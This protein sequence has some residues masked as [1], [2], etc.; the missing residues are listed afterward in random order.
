M[1]SVGSKCVE[2]DHLLWEGFESVALPVKTEWYKELRVD[3]WTRGMNSQCKSL[4]ST[5][6]PVRPLPCTCH[7]FSSVAPQCGKNAVFLPARHPSNP[8]SALCIL[9]SFRWTGCWDG[10]VDPHALQHDEWSLC[11]YNS[12]TQHVRTGKRR[13]F[14]LS[15]SDIEVE[16]WRLV[17]II[18]INHL[19]SYGN[20]FHFNLFRDVLA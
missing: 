7:L 9:A 13:T 19:Q 17:L 10:M 12:E 18:G 3:F 20:F 15:K 16:G 5:P 1:Q 4:L 2:V 8:P 11:E 14:V 6:T